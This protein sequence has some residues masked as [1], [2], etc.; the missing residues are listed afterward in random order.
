MVAGETVW[1]GGGDPQTLQSL[2]LQCQ[3]ISRHIHH[4]HKPPGSFP[5]TICNGASFINM[6]KERF[7]SFIENKNNMVNGS[8]STILL[9]RFH[10]GI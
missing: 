8:D 7:M 6:F 3:Q 9:T 10:P 5:C 4:Y 2:I 1:A